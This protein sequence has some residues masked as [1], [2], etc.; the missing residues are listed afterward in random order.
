MTP[1]QTT[2]A[3]LHA[4]EH[5]AAWLD[6]ELRVFTHKVGLAVAAV[7]ELGALCRGPQ[8]ASTGATADKARE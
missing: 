5:Q 3:E 2:L 7:S 1:F 6:Q 8:A 4:L